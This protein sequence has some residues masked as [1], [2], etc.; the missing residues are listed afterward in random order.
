MRE[1]H[2]RRY[3]AGNIVLA[4]AGNFDWA[5]VRSLAHEYCG[6]WTAGSNRVAFTSPAPAAAGIAMAS[7]GVKR[8]SLRPVTGGPVS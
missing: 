6:A 5:E 2:Q 8:V 1:Y 4:V 3:T 7:A